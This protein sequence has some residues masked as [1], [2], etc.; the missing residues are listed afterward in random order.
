LAGN[1]PAKVLLYLVRPSL[2][3]A[4]LAAL[5]PICL[6][7][8]VVPEAR[9]LLC[10]VQVET[11]LNHGDFLRY[12]KDKCLKLLGSRDHRASVQLDKIVSDATGLCLNADMTVESKDNIIA[13]LNDKVAELDQQAAK[14][15][16]QVQSYR[17]QLADRDREVAELRRNIYIP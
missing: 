6:S 15:Q 4:K 3:T 8:N 11:A 10:T 14:Y 9:R 1:G 5:S 7:C 16:S 12:E 13:R 2:S 17:K